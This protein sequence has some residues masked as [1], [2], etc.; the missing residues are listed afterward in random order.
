[1]V[2]ELKLIKRPKVKP[3]AIQVQMINSS[4]MSLRKQR[5][6]R[7]N[8]LAVALVHDVLAMSWMSRAG[9]RRVR[10]DLVDLVY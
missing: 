9:V 1:M 8:Q 6:P 4:R 10:R 3:G 2:Q 5:K 7:V